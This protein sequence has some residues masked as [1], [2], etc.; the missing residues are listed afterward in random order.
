MGKESLVTEEA[1]AMVGQPLGE[2]ASGEVTAKET[3]RYAH[4][5]GDDNPLYFDDAYAKAAGY[6]GK[7]APPLFFELPMR[8]STALSELRTDGIA[9]ARQSPIPLNVERVMAGGQEVEFIKPVYPGDTL[10][11]ETHLA[12]IQEKTGRSGRLVLVTRET[13]YTNQHGEVV[14]KSRSTSIVR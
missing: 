5:V 11:A 3:I 6:D 12:D 7:I 10:T 14:V 8:E 4:A 1:R 2:S 9:K 13:V